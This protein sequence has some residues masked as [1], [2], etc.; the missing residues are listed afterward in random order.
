ML[1]NY[2]V[3]NAKDVFMGFIQTETAYMQSAPNAL[4]SGFVP[5]PGFTDPDF[6][7]CT[8]D[9]CKKTWGLRVLDSSNVYVLGGG[10]YSFF[11]DYDQTCLATEDCQENMIDIQCSNDIYLMGITTKASVN[12]IN[13]DGQAAVKG[14]DHRN[15]FG[16]TLALFHQG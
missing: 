6:S 5:N 16:Q 7:D 9:K 13:V 15:L 1:Y 14:A 12:M 2:Q 8:S 4:T 11:E 3:N 10:L